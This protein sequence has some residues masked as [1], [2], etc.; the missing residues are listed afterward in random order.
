M[1]ELEGARHW[2]KRANS[3]LACAKIIK[4]VFYAALLQNGDT[5]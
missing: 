4:E 5:T 2:L 1:K 3:N